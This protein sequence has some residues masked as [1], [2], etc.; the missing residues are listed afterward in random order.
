MIAHPLG[1]QLELSS[2][3][4]LGNLLALQQHHLWV[5]AKAV[6]FLCCSNRP[7]ALSSYAVS[8]AHQGLSQVSKD[9]LLLEEVFL[10]FGHKVFA[11]VNSQRP[12]LGI[13]PVQQC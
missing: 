12:P 2:T 6:E 3:F 8:L 4:K 9:L 5:R 11:R 1:L 13:S 10:S 7:D